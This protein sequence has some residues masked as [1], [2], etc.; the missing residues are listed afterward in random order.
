MI[1]G[2]T[3]FYH[4][5]PMKL[6]E[7]ILKCK[8]GFSTS[9]DPN[10]KDLIKRLLTPDLSKRF[11]TLKDGVDDIKNHKWFFGL[12]WEKVLACEIPAPHIPPSKGDGDAS[13]FDVYPEDFEPYSAN[14]IGLD[15]FG[16]SFKDF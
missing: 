10:C 16:D 7:N 12:D 11:G 3:P 5:E 15:A 1:A 9:F 4:E 6:Y 2:Y 14:K 8:P 13:N